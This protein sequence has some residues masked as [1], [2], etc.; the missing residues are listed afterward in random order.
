MADRSESSD[1]ELSE[2]FTTTSEDGSTLD[3]DVDFG[4][5]DSDD[6][7][8]ATI[9]GRA[10]QEITETDEEEGTTTT[11]DDDEDD[12][13]EEDDSGMSSSVVSYTI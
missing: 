4:D 2:D 11:Q 7:D 1:R 3:L 13:D 5:G 8:L 12:D 9:L 6:S 10:A